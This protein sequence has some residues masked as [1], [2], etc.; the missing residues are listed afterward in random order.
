MKKTPRFILLIGNVVEFTRYESAKTL[1]GIKRKQTAAIKSGNC[2][3]LLDTNITT[4]NFC[5]SLYYA[6][7]DRNGKPTS[8]KTADILDVLS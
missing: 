1:T 7:I 8:W 3:R 4:E 6:V 5:G 2:T